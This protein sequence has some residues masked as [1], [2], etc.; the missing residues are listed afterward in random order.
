[1]SRWLSPE[2]RLVR[3]DPHNHQRVPVHSPAEATRELT[4]NPT[5]RVLVLS[6]KPPIS[7]FEP[8]VGTLSTTL[9]EVWKS[10]EHKSNTRTS[11]FATVQ[12]KR[13]RLRRQFG[14]SSSRYKDIEETDDLASFPPG[15]PR[16]RP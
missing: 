15:E 12:C 3:S 14:D 11:L 1:M 8:W 5:F 2:C 9:H 13:T 7:G 10:S 4:K 16:R 6:F